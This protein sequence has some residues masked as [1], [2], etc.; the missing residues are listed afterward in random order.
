[1][2]VDL[3]IRRFERPD[4]PQSVREWNR[5]TSIRRGWARVRPHI[6]PEVVRV[7]PSFE[8]IGRVEFVEA[9]PRSFSGKVLRRVL[10]AQERDRDRGGPATRGPA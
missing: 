7:C 8:R 5:K 2:L 3:E 1:M 6:H 9:V 4:E 10:V